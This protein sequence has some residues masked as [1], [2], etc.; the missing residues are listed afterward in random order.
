MFVCVREVERK[1]VCMCEC[2][3]VNVSVC[4]RESKTVCV[5]IC[6]CVRENI[7]VCEREKESVSMYMCVSVCVRV[8]ALHFL[9]KGLKT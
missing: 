8:R 7:S 6:E 4:V 3:R 2:I 9:V 5:S 1:C